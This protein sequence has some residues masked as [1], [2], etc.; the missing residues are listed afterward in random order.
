M[1]PMLIITF[2]LSLSCLFA[3]AIIKH[4]FSVGDSARK[5]LYAG[6]L[7]SA[8]AVLSF[9]AV[10]D[11]FGFFSRQIELSSVPEGLKR[12]IFNQMK[13][14]GISELSIDSYQFLLS[15]HDDV[16]EFGFD[17]S[18]NNLEL[19]KLRLKNHTDG[20]CSPEEMFLQLDKKIS[21]NLGASSFK[22][23]V[24]EENKRKLEVLESK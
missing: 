23:M 19:K 20:E 10:S 1:I 14:N 13:H 3:F 11:C 22:K 24:Q 8:T 6:V 2:I 16:C 4:E 21:A 9:V 7:S 18:R 17:V 15:G 5:W 12:D